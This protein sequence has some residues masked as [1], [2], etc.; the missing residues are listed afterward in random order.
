MGDYAGKQRF[1][2]IKAINYK[3]SPFERIQG[4][5]DYILDPRKSPEKYQQGWY[6]DCNQALEGLERL[7]KRYHPRGTRNFKHWIISFGSPFLSAD[8]AFEVSKNIADYYGKDYPII[9]GLHTNTKRIH[10]HFLQNTVAVRSGKKFSQSLDDFDKFRLFVNDVL[11]Q[12]K[13]PLLRGV[14]KKTAAENILRPEEDEKYFDNDVCYPVTYYPVIQ[15][16]T[17]PGY[18]VDQVP[19]DAFVLQQPAQMPCVQIRGT[20]DM[21]ECQ[22]IFAKGLH[23][24]YKYGRGRG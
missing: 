13:L 6:V 3:N 12:Y 14:G 2:I 17:L 15:G 5:I 19:Q 4:H 1:A 20:V 8:R 22:D 18:Q 24:F 10:C 23:K 11:A 21:A 9:L 16:N 7:Y